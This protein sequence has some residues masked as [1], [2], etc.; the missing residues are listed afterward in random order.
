MESPG[1]VSVYFCHLLHHFL[2]KFVA[3]LARKNKNPPK[4]SRPERTAAPVVRLNFSHG[5]SLSCAIRVRSTI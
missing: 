4:G 3:L 5:L 1:G 2:N